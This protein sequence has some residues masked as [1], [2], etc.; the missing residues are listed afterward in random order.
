[1]VLVITLSVNMV[2]ASCSIEPIVPEARLPLYIEYCTRW[3]KST[4]RWLVLKIL[5]HFY[6]K[7][8]EN[9]FDKFCR[10]PMFRYYR[11]RKHK[12]VTDGIKVRKKKIQAASMKRYDHNPDLKSLDC[13]VKP[14]VCIFLDCC[15][16]RRLCGS[17]LPITDY[18]FKVYQLRHFLG[19]VHISCQQ[20][21]G[22]PSPT[23][24]PHICN[25]NETVWS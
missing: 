17:G 23:T 4:S 2:M 12:W 7:V 25:L 1:M 9:S 20:S 3:R 24:S 5:W 11:R 15:T 19:P 8:E 10:R 6:T 16:T 13:R 21:R 18:Y 22:Y 14:S